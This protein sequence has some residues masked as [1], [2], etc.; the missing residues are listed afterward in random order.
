MK[1]R[2]AAALERAR[3]RARARSR[4]AAALAFICPGRRRGLRHRAPPPARR[5][6]RRRAGWPRRRRR[7]DREPVGRERQAGLRRPDARDGDR[8]LGERHSCQQGRAREGRGAPREGAGRLQGAD[9]GPHRVRRRAGACGRHPAEAELRAARGGHGGAAAALAEPGHAG[10]RA[11]DHRRPRG[12]PG[13]RR[14]PEPTGP[15]S[16]GLRVPVW[17]HHRRVEKVARRLRAAEGRGGEGEHEFRAR[18]P[19]DVPGPPRPDRRSH[20]RHLR[21]DPAPRGEA[22]DL[23]GNEEATGGNRHRPRRGHGVPEGPARGVRGEG[24]VLRGEAGYAC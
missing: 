4:A 8:R 5:S 13:A 15:R 19:D 23:R 12:S 22:G 11:Q 2:A 16:F 24:Q 3:A 17:E 6:A 21:Q 7:A 14:F 20:G 9:P 10:S 18:R 1:A